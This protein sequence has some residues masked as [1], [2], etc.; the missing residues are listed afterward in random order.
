MTPH[1]TAITPN[2]AAPGETPPASLAAAQSVEN[3]SVRQLLDAGSPEQKR[4]AVYLL[5]HD[6]L[7]DGFNGEAAIDDPEGFLYACILGPG[8]REWLRLH[9][10]PKRVEE[11]LRSAREDEVLSF[12]EV[13]N[14]LRALD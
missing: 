8:R 6:L 2:A 5:L 13:L 3:L 11:L 10:D 4:R 12:D 14:E 9:E 7:G 1:D